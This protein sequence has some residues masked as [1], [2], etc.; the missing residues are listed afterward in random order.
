MTYQN[1][2]EPLKTNLI[3]EINNFIISGVCI[4]N[5]SGSA[6]VFGRSS[7]KFVKITT[8]FIFASSLMCLLRYLTYAIIG[9][10]DSVFYVQFM[11]IAKESIYIFYCMTSWQFAFKYWISSSNLRRQLENKIKQCEGK[12]F[13]AIQTNRHNKVYWIVIIIAILAAVAQ[14]VI[15]FSKGE[16]ETHQEDIDILIPTDYGQWLTFTAFETCSVLIL[17]RSL[18]NFSY[19]IRNGASY[20]IHASRFSTVILVLHAILSTFTAATFAIISYV[21][22]SYALQTNKA[23][24]LSF[25]VYTGLLNFYSIAVTEFS[26]LIVLDQIGQNSRKVQ[27][28]LIQNQAI[29]EEELEEDDD[30]NLINES[31]NEP[32]SIQTGDNS[33][34]LSD[35]Y[36]EK[37]S[38]A[39][40]RSTINSST[41]SLYFNIKKQEDIMRERLKKAEFQSEIEEISIRDLF[42]QDAVKLTYE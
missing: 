28:F 38:V 36:E 2:T 21:S 14:I 37:K 23:G 6:F 33:K 35:A 17:F 22:I 42:I 26:I 20:D 4:L 3:T 29:D 40:R 15:N 9:R 1:Q 19:V 27:M 7:N 32:Q 11:N 18:Y 24:Y 16:E 10:S 41:N 30:E 39:Y 13:A 8:S 5:L 34:L 31:N 25:V 12:S